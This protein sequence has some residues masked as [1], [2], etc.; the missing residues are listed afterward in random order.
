MKLL[1]SLFYK[2][3]VYDLQLDGASCR[4]VDECLLDPDLCLGGACV[5]TD[6]SY[7]CEC[8]PGLTLDTTGMIFPDCFV[9]M[10]VSNTSKHKIRVNLMLSLE[11]LQS[12]KISL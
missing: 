4:D 2:I 1:R 5:N 9:V 11:A 7:R 8:P 12:I 3:L 10:Q 6:G